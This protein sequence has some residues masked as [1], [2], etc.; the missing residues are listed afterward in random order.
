MADFQ[1]RVIRAL[2][3]P[4]PEVGGARNLQQVITNDK[5]ALLLMIEEYL[6]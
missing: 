4:V 3:M 1:Q 6:L 2:A 5:S